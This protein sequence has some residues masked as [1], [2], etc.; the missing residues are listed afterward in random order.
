MGLEM[1]FVA[2]A[3]LF[4]EFTFYEINSIGFARIY[5]STAPLQASEREKLKNLFPAFIKIPSRNLFWFPTSTHPWCG[6]VQTDF[7]TAFS[8][9][10]HLR[11]RKTSAL[12]SISFNHRRKMLSFNIYNAWRAGK[13]GGTLANKKKL[14]CNNIVIEFLCFFIIWL[15]CVQWNSTIFNQQVFLLALWK[16]YFPRFLCFQKYFAL[17]FN[18]FYGMCRFLW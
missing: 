2:G 3:V 15:I 13:E 18:R 7:E 14:A 5:I 1:T 17:M 11:A 16:I 12:S 9:E 8:G 4:R 6:F 10:T